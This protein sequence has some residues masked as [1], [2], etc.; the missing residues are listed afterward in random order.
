MNLRPLIVAAIAVG[1]SYRVW[2]AD[3]GKQPLGRGPDV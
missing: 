1:Y 3:P 2:K